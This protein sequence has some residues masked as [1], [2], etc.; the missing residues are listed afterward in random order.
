MLR[1]AVFV[2]KLFLIFIKINISVNRGKHVIQLHFD[3]S[4]LKET[5]LLQALTGL[6]NKTPNYF[7]FEKDIV[8]Q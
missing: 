1:Y 5:L 7:V 6:L 8:S 4:P 2:F 3:K